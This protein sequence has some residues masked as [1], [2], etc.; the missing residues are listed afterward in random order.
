M[1]PD[2]LQTTMPKMPEQA[3]RLIDLGVDAI[4]DLGD[5]LRSAVGDRGDA[6]WSSTRTASASALARS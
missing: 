2:E 5:R 3:D 6:F 1:P 4:A